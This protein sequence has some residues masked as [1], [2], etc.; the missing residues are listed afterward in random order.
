MALPIRQTE[1]PGP[2][3]GRVFIGADHGGVPLSFLVEARPGS[4]PALHR[5]PY[6][7]FLDFIGMPGRPTSG[8]TMPGS[9]WR[10]GTFP[11]A[12]RRQRSRL[13]Q[14]RDT[15][16]GRDDVST[17]PPGS[18]P[19]AE[20]TTRSGLRRRGHPAATGGVMLT[21]LGTGLSGLIALATT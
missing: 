14:H 11:V 8:S 16:A 13:H 20:P 4:G 1:L 10:P 18:S 5:H 19:V 9:R 17:P 3:E 2:P 15:P 21:D 12:P 7:Q 6:P